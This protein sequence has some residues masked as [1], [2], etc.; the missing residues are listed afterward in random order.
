MPQ[1][2]LDSDGRIN[3]KKSIER[4]GQVAVAYAMA[5]EGGVHNW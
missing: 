3:N 2:I 5:G 4:L 1:G